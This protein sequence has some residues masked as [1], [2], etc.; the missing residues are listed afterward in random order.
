MRSINTTKICSLIGGFS[1]IG[2]VASATPNISLAQYGVGGAG[3]NCV[4]PLSVDIQVCVEQY[5]CVD[6]ESRYILDGLENNKKVIFTVTYKNNGNGIDTNGNRL[7]DLDNIKASL[8]LPSDRVSILYGPGE[9]DKSSNTINWNIDKLKSGEK[10]STYQIAGTIVKDEST[11]TASL[12]KPVNAVESNRKIATAEGN[13]NSCIYDR[14]TAA[15]MVNGKT[16]VIPST[17]DNSLII[18]TILILGSAIS[19]FG[20]RKLARGF[21]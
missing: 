14:D 18:K 20:I 16:C 8:K 10:S 13:I 21:C 12:I 3:D 9:I 19:A 5:G 17:G 7:S 15:F 11:C 1:L 4:N 6:N 2:L